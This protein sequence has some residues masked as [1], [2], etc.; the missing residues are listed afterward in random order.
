M[1]AKAIDLLGDSAF[2]YLVEEVIRIV[3]LDN[4]FNYFLDVTPGWVC[5]TLYDTYVEDWELLTDDQQDDVI[6]ELKEEVQRSFDT[7]Y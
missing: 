6:S 1:P 4:E 2:D 5:R 3:H 7:Y